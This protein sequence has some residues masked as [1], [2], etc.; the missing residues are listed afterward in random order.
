MTASS[1]T[2]RE[3]AG[4]IKNHYKVMAQLCLL[5]TKQDY[6]V[7]LKSSKL[8]II[9]FVTSW[10]Q[11][12]QKYT[13][14]ATAG[15][16]NVIVAKVDVFQNSATGAM[17]QH[18]NITRM[19]TTILFMNGKALEIFDGDDY[20]VLVNKI[21]AITKITHNIPPERGILKKAINDDGATAEKKHTSFAE[22][23]EFRVFKGGGGKPMSW[24]VVSE[25][26]SPVKMPKHSKAEPKEYRGYSDKVKAR[27]ASVAWLNRP[28]THASGKPKVIENWHI[29]P[30]L[31]IYQ[32]TTDSSGKV[33]SEEYS[34]PISEIN[35]PYIKTSSGNYYHLSGRDKRIKAVQE[36]IVPPGSEYSVYRYS[37]Y[38]HCIVYL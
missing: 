15:G 32:T 30:D 22:L 34:S 21:S 12:G 19:P 37:V 31:C 9:D 10:Y 35:G 20:S 26:K 36:N 4:E 2:E 7:L 17:A 11:E 29:K 38:T 27:D 16:S 3:S 8:L 25:G 13:D 24:S 1:P 28:A 18:C 6:D 23:A 14:M 5:E 33:I